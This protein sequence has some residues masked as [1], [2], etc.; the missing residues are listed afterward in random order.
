M[1]F[2]TAWVPAILAILLRVESK[3]KRLLLLLLY[4]VLLLL[5]MG[6][7]RGTNPYGVWMWS[8]QL[9]VLLGAALGIFW[10]GRDRVLGPVIFVGLL[11]LGGWGLLHLLGTGDSFNPGVIPQGGALL[12]LPVQGILLFVGTLTVFRP[13][14][15]EWALGILLL[16]S[17]STAFFWSGG[18]AIFLWF[19]LHLARPLT[20]LLFGLSLALLPRSFPGRAPQWEE[21]LEG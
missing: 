7:L 8:P 14:R 6:I 1:T 15:A 9:G 19:F 2:Q 20:P 17:L 18:Q 13:L 5:G 21:D 4:G 10:R 3:K 16:L 12:P 11:L